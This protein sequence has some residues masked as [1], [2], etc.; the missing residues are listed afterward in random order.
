MQKKPRQK[1]NKKSSLRNG[2]FLFAG[3]KWYDSIYS[4]K[5]YGFCIRFHGKMKVV[6]KK[7]TLESNAGEGERTK[8]EKNGEWVEKWKHI[9]RSIGGFSVRW[10]AYTFL[11]SHSVHL[12]LHHPDQTVA[13]IWRAVK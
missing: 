8:R 5:Q 13:P 7:L 4:L 1:Q 9:D 2:T 11:I 6:R 10:E 12:H 3:T